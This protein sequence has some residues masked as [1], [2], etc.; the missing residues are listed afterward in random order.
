M[1]VED[2]T[3]FAGGGQVYC[4]IDATD[5]V[6]SEAAITAKTADLGS[7]A[8]NYFDLQSSLFWGQTALHTTT[9]NLTITYNCL[10]VVDNAVWTAA[11]QA[12]GSAAQQAGG[13][14]GLCG[15][16][17]GAAAAGAQAAAAALQAAS[18]DDLVFNAQQTIDRSELLDLTNGRVWALRKSG[19]S[20]PYDWDWE[21]DVESWGCSNGVGEH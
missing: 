5:G 11:L 7:G 16:A 12:L 2:I 20:W 4:I 15:W 1:R 10:R 6:T 8:T 13:T 3:T 14:A 17:F 21:I 9:D 18:G 19:G